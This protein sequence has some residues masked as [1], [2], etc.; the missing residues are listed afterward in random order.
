MEKVCRILFELFFFV[1]FFI[2]R[3][4]KKRM[5]VL[6]S[7]GPLVFISV[8]TLFQR[9]GRCNL[10][11]LLHE[12]LKV[13]LTGCFGTDVLQ[14]QEV[15][16]S[17]N[18]IPTD[19]IACWSIPYP[20]ES[21]MSDKC[22]ELRDWIENI[23]AL[24]TIRV[25]PPGYRIYNVCK[26]VSSRA[27]MSTVLNFVTM[28]IMLRLHHGQRIELDVFLFNEH[29]SDA[30]QLYAKNKFKFLRRNGN[31][32]IMHYHPDANNM[33]TLQS[34][35]YELAIL[36][37][38]EH[39]IALSVAQRNRLRDIVVRL[40]TH[41]K[42]PMDIEGEFKPIYGIFC[43]GSIV[44]S[45]PHDPHQRGNVTLPDRE[46]DFVTI[47]TLGVTLLGPDVSYYHSDPLMVSDHSICAYRPLH[48]EVYTNFPECTLSDDYNPLRF[49][50]RVICKQ[51]NYKTIYKIQHSMLLSDILTI[52]ETHQQSHDHSGL[53]KIQVNCFFCTSPDKSI[54]INE[55]VFLYL[56]WW[57]KYTLTQQAV[58]IN[59]TMIDHQLISLMKNINIFQ[60]M[61]Q[62][63]ISLGFMN[64]EDLQL[65]IRYISILSTRV[66]TIVAT[67]RRLLLKT[68][69][70]VLQRTDLDV[71]LNCYLMVS[72]RLEYLVLYLSHRLS[73]ID[74]IMTQ[75]PP[76]FGR[77]SKRRRG[78]GRK[79]SI[80]R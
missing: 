19:M 75:A 17:F 37:H 56:R 14:R 20:L 71:M 66:N 62:F 78:R 46:I 27:R 57:L 51:C 49:H 50:A 60:T 15:D 32:L 43:H 31:N 35:G 9:T 59:Y 13:L 23:S 80:K 58:R 22:D 42:E 70:S 18:Y 67:Y 36:E 79:H 24:L 28:N 39:D 55:S 33:D 63:D 10:S 44:D 30:F 45:Y 77:K 52:I 72:S 61:Q 5:N 69:M 25:E 7:Q 3:Y 48:G 11:R 40:T 2:L 12:K 73:K 21:S 38:L 26:N 54:G 1:S 8:D 64:H 76:T 29:F 34:V 6:V 41:V 53:A 47:D 74:V 65:L 16:V 68:H 4:I